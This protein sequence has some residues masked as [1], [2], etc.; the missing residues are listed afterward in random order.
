[1]KLKF[2]FITQDIEGTKFLVPVG[3]K[4][5]SGIIRSNRTA[6]SIIECLKEE[7]TEVKIIDEICSRY[8]APREI[9]AEDVNRII[10]A[11]RSIDAID[12]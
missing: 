1:M 11:L 3:P 10:D 5:F 4:S 12:E 7:T 2:D 9:I 8:D 6:A